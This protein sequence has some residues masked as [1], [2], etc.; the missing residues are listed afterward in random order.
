MLGLLRFVETTLRGQRGALLGWAPVCLAVGI[1]GYFSLRVE[2]GQLAFWGAL[3]FAVA[4]YALGRGRASGWAILGNG[5]ALV[6]LGFA[7]AQMRAH[8]VAAPRLDMPYQ[9]IVEGRVVTLD[10]SASGALRMILDQVFMPELGPRPNPARVRVSLRGKAEGFDIALLQRIRVP[11]RMAPPGGPVEPG[12][13]DFQRHS[14]FLRLGAVGYA[15]APPV[16]I[17]PQPENWSIARVRDR[18]S[19]VIHRHLSGDTAAIVAAITTGDRS[20]LDPKV[21]ENLRVTNLA[22]LLAISGLHM[23]LLVGVVFSAL[24]FAMATVQPLA[25]RLPVKKI[26]AIGALIAA[27][28]YLALSGGSIATE[29]AFVMAAV[30][31]G[32][33]CLNRRAISMRALA[34]AGE[35]VLT[36]RPESL[37]SPGFQMSFAATAALVWVYSFVSHHSRWPGPRWIKP[38]LAVALTSFV[39]GAATAPF[40][41]AH[42][43]GYAAYGLP[44][45]LLSVPIMGLVIMPAA[46]ASV[47]LAP[48]GLEGIGLWVMGLGVDWILAVSRFFASLPEARVGIAAPP[49]GALALLSFGLTIVFVWQGRGKAMGLLPLLAATVIWTLSGR[50]VILVDPTAKL[51]GVMDG[52]TRVLSRARGQGFAAKVWLENDGDLVSQADAYHRGLAAEGRLWFIELEGRKI[53]HWYGKSPY[54]EKLNCTAQDLFVTHENYDKSVACAVITAGHT[55]KTGALAI[56]PKRTGFVIQSAESVRG[57]RL[58]SPIDPWQ[59][60]ND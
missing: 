49:S 38:V 27:S 59:N 43:N 8:R 56:T 22:H 52:A 20:G 4:G 35:I 14:W 40:A 33:V 3:L 17:E 45:N 34:I 46:L 54:S 51:V 25:L 1:A 57:N 47:L 31:L 60:A 55:K 23:G 48:L 2:P 10:R 39:A 29:R 24:R 12:G 42:F 21:V 15:R 28:G 26:A 18:L 7:L 58:W 9:G 30:A 36:L 6:A 5:L 37:V 19:R 32:A 13:F 53:Y 11:A 50:P 41:A 16:V 44:A